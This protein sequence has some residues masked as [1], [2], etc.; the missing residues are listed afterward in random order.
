MGERPRCSVRK[1]GFRSVLAEMKVEPRVVLVFCNPFDKISINVMRKAQ[2]NMNSK[3]AIKE[4]IN[5]NIQGTLPLYKDNIWASKNLSRP[6]PVVRDDDGSFCTN[7]KEE[8]GRL[9]EFCGIE[10]PLRMVIEVV[11]RAHYQVH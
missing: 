7:T 8:L 3:R 6:G 5:E 2:F 10:C 1:E 4:Y 11:N 9:C